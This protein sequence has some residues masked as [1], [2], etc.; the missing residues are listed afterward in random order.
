MPLLSYLCAII[1][2]G[3]GE[4]S[5]ASCIGEQRHAYTHPLVLLCNCKL[6]LLCPHGFDQNEHTQCN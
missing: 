5:P 1:S 4:D 6:P 3:P 2:K